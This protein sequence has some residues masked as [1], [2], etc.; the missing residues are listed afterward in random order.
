MKNLKLLFAILFTLC[1]IACHRGRHVIIATQ[2]GN[3]SVK[4]EYEGTIAFNEEQTEIEG[5]SRDGYLSFKRNNDELYAA[6][7]G[8]GKITYEL[9][10]EKINKLDDMGQGMLAEAIRMV[11]KSSR[12]K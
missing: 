8:S 7:D 1:V 12:S 3:Y 2:S 10:G 11:V 6:S 9:N 4:L 5:I